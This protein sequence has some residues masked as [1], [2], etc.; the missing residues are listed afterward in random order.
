[1]MM[2]RE[3]RNHW[4]AVIGALAVAGL[5]FGLSL[6]L[7]GAAHVP[8]GVNG[9]AKQKVAFSID[10]AK[11]DIRIARSQNVAASQQPVVIGNLASMME[12]EIP[13]LPTIRVDYR[14][15]DATRM[16]EA[17]LLEGALPL[18]SETGGVAAGTLCLANCTGAGTPFACC[19]GAGT[20][21]CTCCSFAV[22]CDDSNPC[23]DDSCNFTP[24]QPA[25]SGFCSSTVAPDGQDGSPGGTI[26]CPANFGLRCGGCDD[27]LVCNGIETCQSGVCTPG[28]PPCVGNQICSETITAHFCDNNPSTP[29]VS[30]D[31]C[32]TGTCVPS[33]CQDNACG[34]AADCQN[35]GVVGAPFAAETSKKCN[36]T[37]TC[38]SGV[39]VAGTN[40]CGANAI[41]GEKQCSQGPNVDLC[42]IDEDCAAVG[43]TCSLIGPVC[44]PGRCCGSGAEPACTRRLK[45]GFCG[46]TTGNAGAACTSGADCNSGTCNQFAASC[47]G[48][49]GIFYGGDDGTIPSG[50][51]NNCPIAVG[52]VTVRCPKYSAGIAPSGAFPQLLGPVSDSPAVVSPFGVPLQRLGDDYKMTNSGVCVGGTRDGLGCSS[53]PECT[54]GGTC[55][56]AGPSFL[57]LEY[58]RFVGGSP[59]TD[60]ISFE[61]WDENG[62]FVEDLFFPDNAAF[63]IHPVQFDP[64]LLIPAAGFVTMRVAP[65]FSP[66]ARHVWATT[67]V[68]D[69]G[70]NSATLMWVNNGPVNSN[71]GTTGILALELE[72][73]KAAGN[74]GA[75]CY[76]GTCVGG[77]RA[78]KGCDT[79]A[80]CPG[81]T[82]NTTSTCNNH[83][84]SFECRG[85]GGAYL[86]NASLC[87]TCTAGTN[88]GA[89][90][91]SCSNNLATVCNSDADCPGGTCTND[92]GDC[93]TGGVCSSEPACGVGGCCNPTTGACTV[94]SETACTGGGRNYLGDGTDCDADHGYDDGQQ[95]CCPQPLASYSG[96]DN[97]G[98]VTLHVITAPPIGETKVVTITGDNSGATSSLA[99]PD[100]CFPPSTDPNAEP[101]WWEGFTLMDD[102]TIVYVDHCC[103]DPVHRPA[104]R[105]LYD[106]CSNAACGTAR[107]TVANPY[108]FPEPADS[109]GLPY[110]GDDD[111][112]WQSFGLLGQGTYY[113]P[114]YSALAGHHGQYQFHIVARACPKAA[115][116][117]QD[118]CTDDINQ[119]QCDAL[120]GFFL[121]PPHKSPAV[122]ACTGTN[123]Q[124]G[125]T[126]YNGSCC[127][128]PGACT[129]VVLGQSF[130][131]ADCDTQQGNFIGGVRC[132][133][134]S[135]SGTPVE[136]CS[137]NADCP[138][139]ETCIGDAEQ[140][141]QLSPCPICEFA[142]VG[143]CQSYEDTTNFAMSDRHIGDAGVLSADDIKPDGTTLT[144][145]CVWGFT[146]NSDPNATNG[147]CAQFIVNDHFRVRVYNNDATSGRVPSTL[148][149]ETTASTEKGINGPSRIQDLVDP[150][151]YGYQLT[152]DAPITG[153]TPG[154][155]YWLEVSNDVSDANTDCI[156]FWM[157]KNVT[158]TSYSYTGTDT[159]YLP[160]FE[161]PFEKAFCTNFTFTGNLGAATA[162]CCTCDGLCT[163]KTFVD[164]ANANGVWDVTKTSCSG[165]TCPTGAPSND[166]CANF[167]TIP[168]GAY[169]ANNQCATTDG[170]GPIPSDTGDTQLD[171]DLWY[172]FVAGANC[173]LVVAE[174]RSGRRFDS[175]LAVYN[176]CPANAPGSCDKTVCPPCPLDADPNGAT[177]SAAH[178]A[179][180]GRD[181]NCT[182]VFESDG[183]WVASE[184]LGRPAVQGE[185]FLLRI[186]S[187]PGNRG[188]ATFDVICPA[189]G[190][191]PDDVV[192]QSNAN[193][194]G[195]G[196][197]SACCTAAGAGSCDKVRFLSF[198]PPSN[199][200]GETA[201]RIRLMSLH[202]V[203]PPY[204]G[205]PTVVYTAFE[206]QAVYVG[207]PNN[208]VQS[209]ASGTP[210]KSAETMTTPYF[211]DWN[212]VG[213]LHVRGS[214]IVPSSDYMIEHLSSACNGNIGSAACQSGGTSVSTGVAART[215]RWGDVETPYNPPSPTTQ[216]DLADVGAMVN[217]FRGAPGAPDKARVIIQSNNG[218]GSIT[219]AAM[220]VDFGFSH[221]AACV[222]GFRGQAYPAKMGRCSGT[223]TVACTSA[224]DCT[225]GNTP[226]CILNTVGL[227]TARVCSNN[228]ATTCTSDAQCGANNFCWAETCHTDA[229]CPGA[230]GPCVGSP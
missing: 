107:F 178:L 212:T 100:S 46:G 12:G 13:V 56:L 198:T 37:E 65:G 8:G 170:Y 162:P 145:V 175:M 179:G 138:T 96:A 5:A 22:D 108:A 172:K 33:H 30:S 182:G 114:I 131:K 158:S 157:Q 137:V 98:D 61:F 127:T 39:C 152:L 92:N 45:R 139:A 78:A 48:V 155:T 200:Q 3:H 196:T 115:C 82:C 211:Q 121:A 225:G 27:G 113:Y 173:D 66:N 19:T 208:F 91:K 87:S 223:G 81:G 104:Y 95:H 201:L 43:G 88:L 194:T 76:D 143:N 94:E 154:A 156:W 185:C 7:E 224:S 49:G 150:A 184:M 26:D 195:L 68:V 187:F 141:A 130:T 21:T 71:F 122:S 180:S 67:D 171:F 90:C 161:A 190:P 134:G 74:F 99:N 32:G 151:T 183:R 189:G 177:I 101:G 93:G 140:L 148:L 112:A 147:E 133:G 41:C 62:I 69:A 191:V 193:C 165:V 119:F 58:L 38:N 111:N 15:D 64:P 209:A 220:G 168:D 202:H 1:M 23:T 29:C 84:T 2:A 214:A 42:L 210:F 44:L 73:I 18:T 207:P 123:G 215:T 14:D 50:G 229:D 186:G 167:I 103:T 216:P 188:T 36:G 60:R 126:C 34:S 57:S 25:G 204:T 197:P 59:V 228:S 31:Q 17:G 6:R 125:S 105:I 79:N 63:G 226:P 149:G 109:R 86:G 164:C 70:T 47:D 227:C 9:V 176:N 89:Y 206:G 203:N 181:D 166:E 230:S 35:A 53:T 217:K 83:V 72:G 144:Q 97:C 174:C 55:N 54:G 16:R 124:P 128:G 51:G 205:Q 129:D 135:C 142:G 222:D 159:G 118:Q 52:E 117:V 11:R 24:G 213:L 85:T 106:S 169:I 160:G 40:P 116:C 75:C 28:T 4:R 221:I 192:V 163:L 120:G 77:T 110:C 136:S 132:Q 219:N 20:G 146:L 199:S 153:L 10:E 102:C 80:D 218:F